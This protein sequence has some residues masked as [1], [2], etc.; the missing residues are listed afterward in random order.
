M[1]SIFRLSEAWHSKRPLLV[2]AVKFL[3]DEQNLG[4]RKALSEVGCYE[5]IVLS[6]FFH[7]YFLSSSKTVSKYSCFLLYSDCFGGSWLW[8]WPRTVS[9]LVHLG[10]CLLNI[11][12]GIALYQIKTEMSLGTPRKTWGLAAHMFLSS[13]R[14]WRFTSDFYDMKISNSFIDL[15]Y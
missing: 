10:S 1:T 12:Y 8:L 9:W 4:V 2:E 14:D 11:L 7:L 5:L 13:T 15:I 3:L 6:Y